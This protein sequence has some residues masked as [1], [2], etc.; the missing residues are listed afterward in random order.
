[1]CEDTG[2]SY[3][4]PLLILFHSIHLMVLALPVKVLVQIYQISMEAII[5]D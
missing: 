4:E 3:E 5:P 2:I 1:M